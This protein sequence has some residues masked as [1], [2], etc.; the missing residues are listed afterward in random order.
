MVWDNIVYIVLGINVHGIVLC[1]GVLNGMVLSGMV[2]YAMVWYGVT[3]CHT[4]PYY[5][6]R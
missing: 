1:S 5:I 6:I 2:L 3:V 4:I